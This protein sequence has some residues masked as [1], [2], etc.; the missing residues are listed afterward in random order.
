VRRPNQA[1]IPK[2]NW[3]MGFQFALKPS[4]LQSPSVE[5]APKQFYHQP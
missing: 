4:H 1:H 3:N 5:I 2:T